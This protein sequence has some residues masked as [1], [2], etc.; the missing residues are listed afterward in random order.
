[1]DEKDP[2]LEVE[3]QVAVRQGYIYKIWRL[4]NKR[5]ICIRSTIHS[6]YEKGIDEEG[7]P[8]KHYQNNY[9][10]TEY[11]GN[12]VRNIMRLSVIYRQTGNRTLTQ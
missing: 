6:F 1:L 11:E 2:F 7:N 4:A 8:I 12:K 10:F 3:G 9:S 5:K